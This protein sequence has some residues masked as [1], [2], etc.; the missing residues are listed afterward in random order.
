MGATVTTRSPH[1]GTVVEFDEHRGLGTVRDDAG[2]ELPFHCTSL[3][4]GTRS[5][6]VGTP[7]AFVVFPGHRGRLEA[8]SL[9]PLGPAAA[10]GRP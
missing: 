9:V 1:K 4:D 10:P 6:A 3:V 5:V 8:R 2:A 7:V